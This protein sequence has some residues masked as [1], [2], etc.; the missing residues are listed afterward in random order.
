VPV[1]VVTGPPAPDA[2]PGV[3]R[4]FALVTDTAADASVGDL[5]IVRQG[6]AGG[7][8]V[9]AGRLP[10]D[11][12]P[13]LVPPW[14]RALGPPD[15]ERDAPLLDP[16]WPVRH[17]DAADHLR[18]TPLDALL[19]RIVARPLDAEVMGLLQAVGTLVVERLL[20][21][22]EVVP[23][24][25]AVRLLHELVLQAEPS[26]ARL[27]T[28]LRALTGRTD[29]DPRPVPEPL[30]YFEL[31][32]IDAGSQTDAALVTR[33]SAVSEALRRADGW[34]AGAQ[35]THGRV[36]DAFGVTIRQ[37]LGPEAAWRAVL[38]FAGEVHHTCRAAGIPVRSAVSVGAGVAFPEV[39]GR[40]G[41]AGLPQKA[42]HLTIRHAPIF[43][44]P[45]ADAPREGI[46][47]RDGLAL[48]VTDQPDPETARLTCEA[49]W[50]GI[51]EPAPSPLCFAPLP[52][53]GP[54]VYY[55]LRRF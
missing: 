20:A 19:A 13:G 40:F 3:V 44:R 17:V 6:L 39:F 23:P 45:P 47:R 34:L 41:A 55:D 46:V 36:G 52:E 4:A 10:P 38:R 33:M 22:P 9:V 54:G 11:R 49:L 29:A 24:N 50:R 2:E 5:V 8:P 12:L 53:A 21:R 42:V 30:A 14:Y 16:D 25:G 32:L 43:R 37:S 51:G 15:D 26:R 1:A 18:E 31:D 28:A 35:V 48:V 27:A 7:Y